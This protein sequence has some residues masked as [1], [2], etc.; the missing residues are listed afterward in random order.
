[1]KKCAVL[2]AM[3][4]LSTTAW[5][6]TVGTCNYSTCGNTNPCW[7]PCPSLCQPSIKTNTYDYSCVRETVKPVCGPV[8]GVKSCQEG[9]AFQVSGCMGSFG[10]INGGGGSFTFGCGPVFQMPTN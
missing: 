1:M 5:G 3:L 2:L 4:V 6:Y 10:T 7:N 9:S 8:V